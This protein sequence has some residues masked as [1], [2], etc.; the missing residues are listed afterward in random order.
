MPKI[1]TIFIALIPLLCLCVKAQNPLPNYVNFTAENG[2]PS[3]EVYDGIQDE[4][5]YLWFGTDRGVARFNGYEFQQFTTEDGLTDNVVFEL[6]EDWQGRIWF[7]TYNGQ[8]CFFE[9]EKIHPYR[10]NDILKRELPSFNM[11]HSFYV[12][13][14]NTVYLTDRVKSG[15]III[16]KNGDYQRRIERGDFY[17]EYR[18]AQVE[19]NYLIYSAADSSKLPLE[20]EQ[21][22]KVH[23]MFNQK[24]ICHSTFGPV[25]AKVHQ[26]NDSIICFNSYDSLF[27]FNVYQEKMI[28]RFGFNS[29]I[30]AVE[31]DENNVF[32]AF[33]NIGGKFYQLNGNKLINYQSVLNGY[34]TSGYIKDN[35]GGHWYL[36]VD[37]GVFYEKKTA[38][39]SYTPQNGLADYYV[40]ELMTFNEKPYVGFD[41]TVQS[42]DQL[43]SVIVFQLQDQFSKVA[44]D[45]NFQVEDSVLFF[46]GAPLINFRTGFIYPRVSTSA[47]SEVVEKENKYY[48][49]SG[50]GFVYDKDTGEFRELKFG[51]GKM[52]YRVD[53]AL[54]KNEKDFW[55]GS[56][57]GLYHQKGE[58]FLDMA[59]ISPLFACRIVSLEQTDK[60]EIIAGTR[61]SG[62]IFFDGENV[63]N[64]STHN[65]LN[66]PDVTQIYVDFEDN[67][68]VCTY[69]GLHCINLNDL[70]DIRYFTQSDGLI[71]NEITDV[72][73]H[74]DT[75]Y[76]GTREGLS[77]IDMAG[78]QENDY[79]IKLFPISAKLNGEQI[80]YDSVIHIKPGDKTFEFEYLGL[81]YQA[82]GNIE[83][84]YRIHEVSEE[85][86]TTKNRLFR[87]ES[88]PETGT[89]SVEI[90]A[91]RYP[92]GNWNN[93]IIQFQLIFHPPFYKTWWFLITSIL[94]IAG[95]IYLAFQTNLI[96][97]NKHIQNEI[98]R[99][100]L[101]RL[102]KEDYLVL[103]IGKE[104][105]RINKR[106]ILYVQASKDYVEIHTPY[107]RYLYRSTLK[108]IAE[109]L[110]A[111]NFIRVHRSY[112]V[113]KSKIDSISK[114]RVMV[115]NHPLPIGKTYQN[116][117][118]EL[119]NKFS[120]LN[121]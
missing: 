63:F 82:L 110:S 101:Q 15:L 58:H 13:K 53:A 117:L 43:D 84:R 10:Y 26:F 40:R 121:T 30:C 31:G 116:N 72:L 96:A 100:L 6:Y 24:K 56:S 47:L 97:Y 66:T 62:V 46:S 81:N 103:K 49:F 120:E 52:F 95:L 78:Y 11:F 29:R 39:T 83:Y 12:D 92:N 71:S 90:Q 22:M 54:I 107:K 25:R 28:E 102:G 87:L 48:I 98:I 45:T 77:I 105:V 73:R 4:N 76:V 36:T 27:L 69:K 51:N 109:K 68:W 79:P 88:F 57:Q 55:I 14:N 115:H 64:L 113:Q 111:I 20:R 118:K 60:F 119:K 7:L 32:V 74:R 5:G 99:R 9:N 50:K 41:T 8:L 75:V 44:L 86:N 94:V 106:E 59:T 35:E 18:F 67:L 34:S 108:G 1:K 37:K 2:L 3:S 19:N 114:D 61:G 65:G 104:M 89:F 93:E 16:D 33:E 80:A 38:I 23:Y 21:S 91:R 70:N 112:L 85:W 42:I 17:K